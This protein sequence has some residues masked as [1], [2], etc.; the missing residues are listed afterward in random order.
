MDKRVILAIAG[1]G[2]TSHIVAELPTDE[3]ALVLTYTD[4]NVKNLQ[5]KILERFNCIPDNIVLLSYF[6]FL[7]SFCYLPFLWREYRTRG[8]NWKPPPSWTWRISRTDHRYYIDSN[9]RLYHNRLAKLLEIR[10]IIPLVLDR[11]EKYFDRVYIDEFQDFAGHDFNLITAMV[12]ADLQMLFVGDFH[13]HTFDTSRDGNVN[14]DLHSDYRKYSD[15]IGKI[16]MTVDETTLHRSYRCSPDLCAFVSEEL[17]VQ[18]ESNRDDNTAIIIVTDKAEAKRI[19]ENDGII[20]LFY[21]EHYKYCCY[22]RNWGDSKGVDHYTDVCVVLN[23][24]THKKFR[25][26]RLFE[27]RPQTM[28]KLYVACT[29]ARNDLYLV[30]IQL[31]ADGGTV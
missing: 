14:S 7:H 18:M 10:G 27:L 28:N 16:G 21:R 15:S 11:L 6:T 9:R 12:S 4:S 26:G 2:K 24:T 8:F 17:G 5:Y 20:K 22:S 30:P 13:Q 1:S 29:R 19:F 23:K 3:R 25:H 31:M